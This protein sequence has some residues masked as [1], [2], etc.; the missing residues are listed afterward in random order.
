VDFIINSHF[1]DPKIKNG[2]RTRE[3]LRPDQ[4]AVLELEF[5]KGYV[6]TS[7]K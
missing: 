2:K 6:W 5:A 3:K 7:E 4:I 1:L